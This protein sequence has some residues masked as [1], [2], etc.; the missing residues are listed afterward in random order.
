M[1]LDNPVACYVR[2]GAFNALRHRRNVAERDYGDA[3]LPAWAPVGECSKERSGRRT[4]SNEGALC[5]HVW[6]EGRKGGAGARDLRP[7]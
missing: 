1:S 5:V 2:A 4:V 6:Q 3:P 7:V